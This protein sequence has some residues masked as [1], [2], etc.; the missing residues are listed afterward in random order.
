MT[1]APMVTPSNS[2][3]Y[4]PSEMSPWFRKLQAGEALTRA[5]W[6]NFS[7]QKVRHSS[8]HLSTTVHIMVYD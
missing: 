3:E 6:V 5:E 4:S 1:T 8:V 7:E 2:T